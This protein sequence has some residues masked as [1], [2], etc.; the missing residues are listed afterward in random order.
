M[1]SDEELDHGSGRVDP[2][3]WKYPSPSEP[4]WHVVASPENSAC[5]VTSAFRLNLPRGDHYNLSDDRLEMNGVVIEGS[6]SILHAKGR[7]RLGKFDSFYLPA[8]E[9]L[10][11]EAIDEAIL[12]LGGGPYEGTGG[13]F[14]RAYESGLPEGE[15]HQTHGT[16]PYQRDVFMTLNQETPA[17][18]MINGIT[19]GAPGMWTSWPPHQHTEDLEEVYC[20]FDIPTDSFAL[21]LS[22]R[23]PGTIEAV[24]PVSSGDFVIIPEGYHPTVG[25]P[26]T[27][28]SYFWIMVAHRHASRSYELAKSDFGDA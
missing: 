6:V 9:S 11:I 25:A 23:L 21:H 7:R 12:Y 26:G 1:R 13:F 2:K 16:P 4:G 20:Y 10:Q 15:I 24:H 14:V 19:W 8:A 18:R 3:D 28:S 5:K 17:S 27:R 22:S